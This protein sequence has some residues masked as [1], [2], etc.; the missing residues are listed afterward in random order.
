M[1]VRERGRGKPEELQLGGKSWWD[2]LGGCALA[3]EGWEGLGGSNSTGLPGHSG[4]C[5]GTLE[6]T[7]AEIL[8]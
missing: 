6:G 4:H 3:F 8:G 7:N 2:I 1:P 5:I